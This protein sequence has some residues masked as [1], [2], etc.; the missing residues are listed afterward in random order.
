MLKKIRKI[1]VY[2]A[3]NVIVAALAYFAVIQQVTGAAN[4]LYL[5]VGCMLLLS[6]VAL[7]PDVLK[8]TA[9]KMTEPLTRSVPAWINSSIDIAYV[10]FFVWHSWWWTGIAFMIAAALWSSAM[11]AIRTASQQNIIN[12]LSA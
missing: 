6:I 12:K 5:W 4:I 8:Q 1:L 10:L 2:I 7:I 3:T 9:E 11:S